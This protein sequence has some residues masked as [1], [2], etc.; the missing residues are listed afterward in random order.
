MR[1]IENTDPENMQ[2]DDNELCHKLIT[3]MAQQ[4][5]EFA[6]TDPP[7]KPS[8][9]KINSSK[10]FGEMIEIVEFRLKKDDWD[11]RLKPF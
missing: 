1:G 8:L 2:Q 9:P 5:L 6:G 3:E 4:L 11:R 10:K 7:N